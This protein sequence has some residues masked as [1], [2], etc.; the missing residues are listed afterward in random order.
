[1]LFGKINKFRIKLF[2]SYLRNFSVMIAF[3]KYGNSLPF[4]YFL[5][6]LS[7]L[8][9]EI[10]MK[11]ILIILF[12]VSQAITAS[13]QKKDQKWLENAKKSIVTIET[14]TKEGVKKT[15]S[16]FFILANGEVVALYELFKN[17]ASAV[18]ITSEGEQL[19]VTQVIGADDMYNV[20]RV[21]VAVPKKISFLPV[22]KSSPT[23]QSTVYL[24]STDEEN[25]LK[26]GVVS[27][28]S[29]VNSVYDYFQIDMATPSTQ[30]GSPLLT[31]TGEV[32]ALTQAD[33]SGK[34]KTFGISIAYIQSLQA[35]ATDMFKQKY[36]EIGIRAAW[37][38]SIED[39]QISLIL[40]ASQQDPVTYLETL[41][42]FIAT[43]P[44]DAESYIKRASHYAFR[45]KELVPTE[46]EQLQLLEKAWNDL[47]SAAKITKK[48]GDDF[49]Q[50]AYL[51]FGVIA[52]DSLL[53]YKN[54]NLKSVEEF[55]Q[56]AI[57][58]TDLPRYR[59]LE[60]EIAYYKGNY[61]K[62]YA[63]FSIVTKSP[64]ATG[65]SFYYAAKTKQQQENPDLLEIIALLDSAVAKSPQLE[66]GEYLLEN[67]NLKLQLELY[68]PAIKDYDKYLIAMEG[69][70]SD[71]FYYY[72]QQAKYRIGDFEGALKDIEMAILLDNTNALYLAEKASICLRLSDLP[73]AQEFA[74][75]AIALDD[76]FA[77]A[78]RLLGVC[79]LRQEKKPEACVHF[80]KAKELGDP[81]VDR[82]IKE[83]CNQ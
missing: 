44:N 43:F 2:I 19:P 29:K 11:H 28:I 74:E 6:F 60:G 71:M 33:A 56:K 27:V 80:N 9:K 78:Y 40:Y 52:G 63:S 3:K 34:G 75:K 1:M 59:Q 61:E 77:S 17:A 37:S 5:V 53:T 76:E 24:L 82:L 50:K 62:A 21:K 16:G 22:A 47:E 83:N 10:R 58:A 30:L 66:I 51:I 69:N 79:L 7:V 68:E 72:R 48:K 49:Y 67:I 14:T 70:V 20:I 13:A 8:F 15:G 81:V 12:A 31:E 57:K 41:N 4:R 46:S 26:Q 55:I 18:V 45:R 35:T 23:F 36:A 42:D 64:E 65:A 73:K 54:W 32:F 39:A 38:P 25:N